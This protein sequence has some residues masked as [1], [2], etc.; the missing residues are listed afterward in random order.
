M[1][2]INL[3]ELTTLS[4][5][6]TTP[7]GALVRDSLA[8]SELKLP[9]ALRKRLAA[10]GYVLEESNEKE[11]RFQCRAFLNGEWIAFASSDSQENALTYSML[12]AMREGK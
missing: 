9:A 5:K 4:S 6:S 1:R 11:G 10:A 3:K 8:D 12:G 7:L 2:E